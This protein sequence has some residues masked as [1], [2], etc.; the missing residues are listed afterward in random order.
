MVRQVVQS[1]CGILFDRDALARANISDSVF[2]GQGFPVASVDSTTPTRGGKIQPTLHFFTDQK[3]DGDHDEPV[4]EKLKKS[5]EANASQGSTS[6]DTIQS[7]HDELRKKPMWWLLE[8]IPTNYT[9]QDGS[10]TWHTKWRLAS[11]SADSF[12]QCY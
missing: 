1:Q 3:E 12:L 8:M 6:L 10:G 4:V 2:T 11:G 7:I 5:E 9:Y